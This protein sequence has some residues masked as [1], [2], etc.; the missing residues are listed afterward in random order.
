MTER[1]GRRR[2][3]GAGAALTAGWTC[4]GHAPL[5]AGGTCVVGGSPA[6]PG[7]SIAAEVEKWT[8]VARAAGIRA[9]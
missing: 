5:E 9:D 2:L 8:Q 4:A 1:S 6:H 7:A 3:A